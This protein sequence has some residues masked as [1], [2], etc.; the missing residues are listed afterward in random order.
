MVDYWA[1]GILIYEMLTG[2][3]PFI[4]SNPI[5]IFNKIIDG[6]FYMPGNLSNDAVDLITK[7]L[8]PDPA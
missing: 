4:D 7:L 6:K 1:L 5:R 2:C 3:P 8:N